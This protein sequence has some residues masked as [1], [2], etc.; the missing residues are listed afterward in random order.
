MRHL[1]EAK[2]GVLPCEDKEG[3]VGCARSGRCTPVGEVSPLAGVNAMVMKCVHFNV[4][5]D[6]VCIAGGRVE[7]GKGGGNA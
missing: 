7:L 6:R 4:C 2:V 3:V 1:E 5:D